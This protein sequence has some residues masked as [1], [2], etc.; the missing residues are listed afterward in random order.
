MA[1]S[2]K[3]SRRQFLKMSGALATLPLLGGLSGCGSGGSGMSVPAQLAM[4]AA[5]A[6]NAIA[7]GS[8][9][10]TDYITTLIA[11]AKALSGLNAIITLN[12][13]GAL[14]AAKAIDTARLNGAALGPLAGL[15]IVVKDNINTKNLPTTGGTTALQHFTPSFTAPALQALLDAGAIILGKA[16]LHEL[17][18]GITSTNL[19]TFAGPV[20]NPYNQALIPGGSSGGTAAA[21]SARI[22]PAGIGT[23]TGGSARIPAALTGIVGF[24]PSV[25]NGGADRRYSAAGLLPI[26]HTRDTVGPFGRTVAD[27]ALLDAVMSASTVP[28]AVSLSGLRLGISQNYWSNLDTGLATVMTAAKAKLAAAGVVFVNLDLVGITDLNNKSSFQIAL[29]E[30]IAD[31]PAYLLASGASGITVAS[32]AAQ[33]ASPDVQGAFSAIMGDVYG[34]QY[35]AAISTYRPQLQAL[36]ASYFKTNNIDALFFPTTPLPAVPIDLVKG[37]STVSLN[38][39]AAVDEFSTYIQNT[40]PGSNAGIPGLSLP[41]GFTASGLPVGMA[42]DGPLGSDKKLLGIGLAMEALFG[43]LTAPNI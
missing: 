32:I 18:F 19:S 36:Y 3:H 39:G 16:N 17:A 30:P 25:G 43:S 28:A 33:V 2:K 38:G 12:E 42:I 11:R 40:D 41:A 24:R 5:Q 26:S 15:P 27:V 23:D 1:T 4:T 6:V 9:S 22:V 31:I 35:P 10:A 14:A 8:V 13:A 20:K 34:S 29:H 7:I 21:I 37:S